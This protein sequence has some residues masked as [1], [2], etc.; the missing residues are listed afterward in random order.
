MGKPYLRRYMMLRHAIELLETR[1][2]AFLDP[3]TWNDTND[4]HFLDAYKKQQKLGTLRAVCFTQVSERHHHWERFSPRGPVPVLAPTD[5]GQ[6]DSE[7]VCIE[8]DRDSLLRSLDAK[9]T[10]RW[11]KVEYRRLVDLE[12]RPPPVERWPFIKRYPYKD[13]SEFRIIVARSGRKSGPVHLHIDL[14]SVRRVVVGPYAELTRREAIV[15]QLRGQGRYKGT[16]EVTKTTILD[17]LRWKRIVDRAQ[18]VAS[19]E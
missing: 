15:E 17:N 6:A 2:L 14:E 3:A 13:E 7:P 10:I 18:A 12:K 4:S 9:S 5:G 1:K 19:G 11:D 16:Y 8:F